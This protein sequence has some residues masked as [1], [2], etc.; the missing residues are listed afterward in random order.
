M[1]YFIFAKFLDYYVIVVFDLIGI[2]MHI[3]VDCVRNNETKYLVATFLT[4]NVPLEFWVIF[5]P[6][7]SL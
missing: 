1:D 7:V 5:L 2:V 3:I 6:Y 4:N